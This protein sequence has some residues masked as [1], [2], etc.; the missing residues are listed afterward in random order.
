[1]KKVNFLVEN[2]I[3]FLDVRKILSRLEL[4]IFL[5]DVKCQ[6]DPSLPPVKKRMNLGFLALNKKKFSQSLQYIQIFWG[7]F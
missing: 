3:V 4:I 5:V 2:L 1:M 7:H 6:N